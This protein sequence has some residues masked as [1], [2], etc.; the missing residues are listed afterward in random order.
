[1]TLHD[2]NRVRLWNTND[3]RCVMASP[4]EMLVT[5]AI[6][7]KVIKSHPGNIL[8]IGKDKDVYIINVYKMMVLKHFQYDIDGCTG[9]VFQD[10]HLIICGNLSPPSFFPR[11]NWQNLHP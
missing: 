7:L 4:R 6:K 9:V 10:R 1:M 11:P 3:G 5:K 2:D 8:L